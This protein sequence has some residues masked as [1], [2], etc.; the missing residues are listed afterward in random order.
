PE[1]KWK[2]ANYA[3][4]YEV[5]IATSYTFTTSLVQD[6]QGITDLSRVVD[7]LPDGKY[8]WRVRAMNANNVYGA[9][10]TSRYFTV[11]TQAPSAPILSTPL[12]N[13]SVVGTPTF[14]WKASSSAVRY[15]FAYGTSSDPLDGFVYQSAELTTTTHKPPIMQVMTPYF[16]FVRARDAAGNWSDWSTPPFTITSVPPVPAAP[17]LDGPVSGFLTN[18]T[19]PELKWKTVNYAVSYELQVSATSTF[20]TPLVQDYQGIT[21]LSRVVDPLPD[22]KYYWRVRAMNVNNVYGAWTASRYFTVDTKAPSAPNP[23]SLADG[24]PTTSTK[25]ALS[26]SATSGAVRYRFQIAADN[27]FTSPVRDVTQAGTAYTTALSLIHI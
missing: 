26:V 19:T 22:G 5:Q 17:A 16:W 7:P 23:V 18:N 6:Y 13:A 27:S 8:Y 12:N 20:T 25:P 21:D 24:A 4:S 9:W 10:A 1:L 15:Q 2:A 3:V 14:A 11:D